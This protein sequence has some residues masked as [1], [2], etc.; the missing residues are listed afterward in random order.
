MSST[1]C[2]SKGVMKLSDFDPLSNKYE[3]RILRLPDVPT[4]DSLEHLFTVSTTCLPKQQRPRY[5][6]RFTE[7]FDDS[8]LDQRIASSLRLTKSLSSKK[9]IKKFS[10]LRLL[11][12]CYSLPKRSSHQVERYEYGQSCTSSKRTLPNAFQ[13]FAGLIHKANKKIRTSSPGNTWR[14]ETRLDEITCAPSHLKEK[15][16]ENWWSN[17]PPLHPTFSSCLAMASASS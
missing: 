14:S 11:R 16:T 3:V 8:H 4:F 6:S 1:I 7:V 10:S 17:S 9:P 5:S 13:A 2:F 15:M 12:R